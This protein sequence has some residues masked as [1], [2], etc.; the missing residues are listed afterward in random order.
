MDS[1]RHT[2]Q[3]IHRVS[4][5]VIVPFAIG[6]RG[7]VRLRL[8]PSHDGDDTLIAAIVTKG[9]L[10]E[11]GGY[12]HG[13]SSCRGGLIFGLAISV[14]V[15]AAGLSATAA[16]PRPEKYLINGRLVDAEKKLSGQLEKNPQ[17]DTVRFALGAAVCGGWSGSGRTCIDTD[18]GIRRFW[19]VCADCPFAFFWQSAS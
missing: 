17:D 16:E 11:N 6:K 4:H 5:S 7:T 1:E 12:W 2:F 9:K 19:P 18:C 14:V 8:S 15:A 3:S 10:T 13:G